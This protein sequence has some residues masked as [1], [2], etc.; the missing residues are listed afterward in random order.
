MSMRGIKLWN[1]P[2]IWVLALLVVAGAGLALWGSRPNTSADVPAGAT[3]E[4][5]S[6]VT[7][8]ISAQEYEVSPSDLGPQ[9]PNRRQDLRTYFRDEGIEVVPRVEGSSAWTWG[10]QT[11]AWGRPGDLTQIVSCP[12]VTDATRIEYPRE[13]IVEWYKNGPEGIEQGFTLESRPSGSGPLLITGA[14]TGTLEAEATEAGRA[15]EFRTAAGCRVLR[16]DG[17][18]ACDAR[19]TTLPSSIDLADGALTIRIDD[20]DAVY[21]ILVD[22]LLTT[23]DWTAEGGYDR[24]SF[25]QVV[26]T[27]GDV[28]GDGYSDVVISAPNYSSYGLSNNGRV[29]AFYGSASGL[30]TTA[31]WWKVGDQMNGFFGQTLATAGDVNGDG[32]DDILIGAQ[33]YAHGESHEGR[34]WLYYGSADGLAATSGWDYEGDQINASCGFAIGTAGDVNKDGYADVFVS[35]EGYS[36]GQSNEGVVWVFHGS[37]DGLAATPSWTGE[38]NSTNCS[39]GYSASTAGDVDGDGYADL[40][41]SAPHYDNAGDRFG[42]VYVFYGSSSGLGNTPWFV[43]PNSDNE[44]LGYCVTGV[45]DVN[46]DGYADILVSAPTYSGDIAL[47]GIVYLYAGSASGPLDTPVWDAEGNQNNSGW[48]EA[49]AAAGDVNGDGFADILVGAR[50]WTGDYDEEGRASLYLGHATFLNFLPDWTVYGGQTEAHYG[51]SVATAGD[52]NG[53][54]LSEIIVGAPEYTNGESEEGRAFV[55][56]GVSDAPQ[57]EFG[58]FMDT[59]QAYAGGGL[60]CAAAGDVNGDGY[61]DVLIGVGAYDYG[62]VD[63]GVVFLYLGTFQGLASSPIWYAQSNQEQAYLGQSVACA[64]DVNGDGLADILAGAPWYDRDHTDEGAAFVWHGAESAPMG[65]PSNA[66]WTGTGGQANANY[67]ISVAGA[68]D[69]NG[70]GYA[71]VIVGAQLYDDGQAD[72]GAAFAYYGSAEG[73]PDTWDWYRDADLADAYF[74]HCVATAGDFNGDGFSD[75]IV[76]SYKYDHP[77]VDEGLATVYDGSADGLTNGAPFWYAQGDEAEGWL[78]YSVGCAGDINGDGYSDI[79]IGAPQLTTTEDNGGKAFVWYGGPTAPESGNPSNADWA[80]QRNRA[81]A[82]L[83]WCVGTAGD[84]NSDGYSDVLISTPYQAGVDDNW[85]VAFLWFGCSTGVSVGTDWMVEGHAT[86][87][88]FAAR[89]AYVGDVNGDGF[90]DVMI[91]APYWDS[92]QADEGAVFLYYGNHGPGLNRAP[93]Q[94]QADLSNPIAPLGLSDDSDSFALRGMGRTAAGRGYVRMVWEVKDFLDPFDGTDVGRSSWTNTGTPIEPAGSRVLIARTMTGLT[95]GSLPHW[96]LRFEARNPF[97]PR[98]PWLHQPGNGAGEADLRMS[99]GS[100]VETPV[101]ASALFLAPC[102]PNPML[103]RGVIRYAL[104]A[105]GPVRITMHDVEGRQVAVLVD[106]PEQAAG[107]HAVTWDGSGDSGDRVGAGVYFCRM[108]AAGAVRTERILVA[109]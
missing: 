31:D 32:Y 3:A 50:T 28:N 66:D 87:T 14:L 106:E 27:A 67:G 37:A 53:D 15:V 6:K 62:Q 70:D 41:V 76:G 105:A 82:R 73:L 19:G 68:G 34:V 90:G 98:G 63:E 1:R 64:G 55:Y 79:I 18:K 97:F 26:S 93:M 7:A 23:P 80:V 83:G 25:G 11:R 107:M 39:F 61:D 57:L 85:G 13:S 104:P 84:V 46:G 5:W 99:V 33:N 35:A 49:I 43:E 86:Y 81:G 69:V 100:A 8:G 48:G 10:W 91:C 22:P 16:Y 59:N 21:P 78:G 74:G 54:G 38:V 60:T 24:V 9:A 77:S 4:W 109:R 20:A 75:V 71:D 88:G 108:E 2:W 94:W 96:R 72:E 45:G 17:L 65:N 52:V 40:V 44:S 36:H 89:S 12:P 101:A 51:F 29:F 92:G 102:A 30:H 95:P 42:R 58:V 56:H 47:E 103:E